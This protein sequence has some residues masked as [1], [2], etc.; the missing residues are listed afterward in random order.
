MHL[1]LISNNSNNSSDGIS[2]IFHNYQTYIECHDNVNYRLHWSKL[3]WLSS[4]LYYHFCGRRFEKRK[5]SKHKNKYF[6]RKAFRYEEQIKNTLSTHYIRKNFL[7]SIDL[8]IYRLMLTKASH[9]QR[10]WSSNNSADVDICLM[11]KF[12]KMG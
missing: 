3:S 10:L 9:L 8:L 5:D 4:Q 6:W 7:R 12:T 1:L 2:L 11:T